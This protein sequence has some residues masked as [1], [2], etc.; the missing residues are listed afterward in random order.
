[1]PL[2]LEQAISQSEQPNI[3]T[4]GQ[5]NIETLAAEAHDELSY[6]GIFN[7]LFTWGHRRAPQQQ[8]VFKVLY[9]NRTKI[10]PAEKI[11]R[12][13][14]D[15]DYADH[16]LYRNVRD[17]VSILRARIKEAGLSHMLSIET[18]TKSG[19]ALIVGSK[20]KLANL[21]E[22]QPHEAEYVIVLSQILKGKMHLTPTELRLFEAL[23]RGDCIVQTNEQLFQKVLGKESGSFLLRSYVKTLRAKLDETGLGKTYQIVNFY[24]IGYALYPNTPEGLA[25]LAAIREK[26]LHEAENV[27]VLTQTLMLNNIRLSPHPVGYLFA[28]LRMNGQIVEKNQ[29]ALE[30]YGDTDQR[31]A[32]TKVNIGILRRTIEGG[33]INGF[34]Y[35]IRTHIGEGYSIQAA[36]AAATVLNRA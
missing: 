35:P 19:Y 34:R 28:L 36:K 7:A 17:V 24:G 3:G 5:P 12:E 23:L 11:I 27:A 14:W 15:V 8:A 6:T 4:N 29:L 22:I 21:K 9:R 20:E 1:M 2:D 30:V 31:E 18:H 25:R 10:V 32:V 16:Y 13:A 33:E 26:P